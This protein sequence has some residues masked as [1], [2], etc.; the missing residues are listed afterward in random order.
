[1]K[2]LLA[3]LGSRS[4]AVLGAETGL[5]LLRIFLGLSMALA[6]GLG[7]L[8]PQEGFVGFLDSMGLPA[9]GLMAWLAAL[10]EFGGGLLLAAGLLTRFASLSIIITMTVAA[11]GAHGGD[12]FSE[13]EMALLYLF[14]TLPF[15]FAGGGRVSADRALGLK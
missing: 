12:G 14:A 4:I 7:K 13:Q 1:M 6:H 2:K 5:T 9:P 3:L 11:F 15:L 10:A 8:P